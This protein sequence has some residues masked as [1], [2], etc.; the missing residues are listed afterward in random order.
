MQRSKAG[1]A[2]KISSKPSIIFLHSAL[3]YKEINTSSGCIFVA[4]DLTTVL[5]HTLT[6]TPATYNKA[7]LFLIDR[8]Y[9]IG[10]KFVWYMVAFQLFIIKS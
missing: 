6:E 4:D 8:V 7:C 2:S 5:A 9:L 10:V 1:Y 3:M